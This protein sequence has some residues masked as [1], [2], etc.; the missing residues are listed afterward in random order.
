MEYTKA[1]VRLV[2]LAIAIWIYID[3]WFAFAKQEGDKFRFLKTMNW[4]SKDLFNFTW[5]L[6]NTAIALIIV[7]WA[8][9]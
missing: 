2:S 9:E 3:R 1:I 8:W 6:I 5:I 4:T 7:V